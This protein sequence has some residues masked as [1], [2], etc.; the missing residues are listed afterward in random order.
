MSEVPLY[1]LAFQVQGSGGSDFSGVK[2][3][4]QD[5]EA[6]VGTKFF[7][8]YTPLTEHAAVEQIWHV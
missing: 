7:Q 1:G 4:Q 8:L 6:F 2:A 5:G 3:G